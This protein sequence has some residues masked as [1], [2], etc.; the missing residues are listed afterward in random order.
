MIKSKIDSI[1]AYR[2]THIV[3]FPTITEKGYKEIL[4]NDLQYNIIEL[5]ANPIAY[6][7]LL[8]KLINCFSKE[9]IDKHNCKKIIETDLE[10]LFY[11]GIIKVYN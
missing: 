11:Y 8:N 6:K 5:T 1:S 2:F 10:K 7:D 3:I 4:V 9:I